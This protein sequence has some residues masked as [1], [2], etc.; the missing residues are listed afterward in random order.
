[1]RVYPDALH[2]AAAIASGCEE[3]WANDERLIRAAD[4]RIRVVSIDQL[5]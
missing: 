2:L 1:M 3:P 5:A 4:G